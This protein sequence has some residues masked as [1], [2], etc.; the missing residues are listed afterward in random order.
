MSLPKLSRWLI[1]LA[2]LLASL[3]RTATVSA[4]HGTPAPPSPPVASPAASPRFAT[5]RSHPARPGWHHTQV[6]SISIS[7]SSLAKPAMPTA[8]LPRNLPGIAPGLIVLLG[9][10]E[11]VLI[12]LVVATHPASGVNPAGLTLAAA[13]GSRYLTLIQ[14][15]IDGQFAMAVKLGQIPADRTKV[16]K[17]RLAQVVSEIRTQGQVTT[18][19]GIPAVDALFNPLNIPFLHQGDQ[20]DPKHLA[21]SLPAHDPVLV[22]HGTKDGQVSEA[23]TVRLMSGFKQ[24]GNDAAQRV[25]IPSADHM[26][27]IVPGTPNPVTDYANPGLTFAPEIAGALRAFLSRNGLL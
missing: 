20:Y 24:R 26:F 10:S 9:H 3:G 27:R 18:K 21:A 5:T 16:Y 4:Q 11:G 7:R 23:D 19:V 25:E 15:Q 17:D 2:L 14:D 8:S 6:A 1:L 13:P 12:A 22:L